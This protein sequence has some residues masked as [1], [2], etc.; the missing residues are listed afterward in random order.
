MKI[1]AYGIR[2]DEK[3]F[4]KEWEQENPEVEVEITDKL[5]DEETV[6]MAKGFD[7][8]VVYQQKPYT[9]AVFKKLDAYGIHNVSLRNV[10][11]DNMNPATVKKYGF[12]VTNVPVYSPAAIAEFSVTQLMN[13]LRRTKEYFH[14]FERNDFRWAPQI[15][16]ELNQQTVGVI[17]TGHIGRVAI[18]IY[19]GFGAKVIAYD[20]YHN[21][22]LE[23][24]GLYVDTLDELYAKATVVT[25]HIPLFPSTE[26]M[27]NQE[28]F[29]KMRDGVFIV[30]ASRGPLIDEQA[31]IDALDS[32]KVAGAALDVLEDETK[33]FNHDMTG[34]NM[35]Y[36]EFW[37][38]NSREN[39]LISPHTAFY[40]NVAVQNMVKYSLS[41]NKDLIET[42]TSDKLVKFD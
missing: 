13:L 9:D 24:E 33:V 27:L 15:S 23:K 35:T 41:A 16:Q 29:D 6:V 32:G 3:P 2:E 37:N 1:L 19:K 21:P 12:K 5:L 10:G 39:V 36:P 34:K 31:L 26:H 28:A 14:K 4:V 7:G 17:G 38:L 40:T 25:L 8:V 22:E 30:N 18:D 42:G 11:V 20:V